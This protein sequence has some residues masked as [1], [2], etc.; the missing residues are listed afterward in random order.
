MPRNRKAWSAYNYHDFTPSAS[1]SKSKTPQQQPRDSLTAYLNDLPG[2]DPML[3]G[4]ILTTLNPS[5]L[6]RSG[7]IQGIFGYEH[8]IL[9]HAAQVAQIEMRKIQGSRNIWYA[10]A[11]LGYGFHED[12]FRTGVEAARGVEPGLKLPFQIVD[13][14]D[15]GG[16]KPW[17]KNGL[18]FW[19]LGLLIE[20]I[21]R[22][23]LGWA[24]I[25]RVGLGYR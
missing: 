5:H 3:T 16:M 17:E 8:P 21:Q 22:V 6:P 9:D 19:I 4:P 13:W 20:V 15:D 2:Q 1:S 24:W 7:T 25:L 18:R 12:G 14:K 11:W 23:I 10:G